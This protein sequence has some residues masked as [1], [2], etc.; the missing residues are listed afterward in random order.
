MDKDEARKK[1]EILFAEVFENHPV[2]RQLQKMAAL[3]IHIDWDDDAAGDYFE[4]LKELL[5]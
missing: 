2:E 1:L 4:K 5:K 3:N